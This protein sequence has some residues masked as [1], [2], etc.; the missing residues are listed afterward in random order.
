MK[1]Q[2]FSLLK[3]HF[4]QNK[5]VLSCKTIL[6]FNGNYLQKQNNNLF[7]IIPFKI[8]YL[9]IQFIEIRLCLPSDNFKPLYLFSTIA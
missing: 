9:F 6:L 4:E 8:K 3:I 5:K 2:K 1:L 7:F